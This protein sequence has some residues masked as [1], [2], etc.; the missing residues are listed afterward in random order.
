M[1]HNKGL[2]FGLV[3]AILCLTAQMEAQNNTSYWQQHVDYSMD[4]N[5]DVE[6]YQYSGTQKLV[7]TNNS[8]DVLSRVY[9][10]LFFNAFQPGS[11]MDMRLQSVAD[12]DG[13]MMAD[14]KSRIASLSPEEMGYL[15]VNSLT[16][17]NQAVSF[18]E[19]GTILVVELNKPIPAGGKTTFEMTFNGQIPLQIRRSG[20]NSSEGVALSMSQ[21]Y[22]KL[23]EYDFEGWHADPYI[24][25]EFHGVW[26]D[27]DVKL[28]LDKKY[29][30][31]GTGYL[32]NP[33]E[34]GHGYETPGSKIKKT[35][36]KTLTWHFK[37]P[38]VHDFMWAADPDYL[39]DTL[40]VE[41]GPM[42]HFF[43]KNDKE[44]VEN[45]KKLQPKTAEAMQFFN[46]NI[47]DYPYEQY[48]VIQGG[49][50][51]MEYAMSTLITGG[52]NF[53]SLVGVMVHE[54]AHSWFQHVLA[55]NESKHEWMDEGFTTFISSLCMDQIMDQKK[56][57]P[58]A[59]SYQGYYNLVASGKEQPQTTHA[60]RYE[61]NFAYGVAAYSKGAIFL[62]QL[63][64]IIGQD[65]LMETLRKYYQDFKFKHPTP[66]DIKRTAEKV[67]GMELDWYL[68]DWTQTTNTID[69]GI[70]TVEAEGQKTKVSLERIGLM[71]MPLDILVIYNDGTQETFY[72]PLRMMYGEKENPY[73]HLKRTVLQDWPW[74]NTNYD[75]ILDKEFN[76]VKAIVL[77]PSQLMADV[78]EENNVW[79]AQE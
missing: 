75:L 15:R 9:Y 5:V 29:V 35:K 56:E 53:G 1:R 16:Q 45:W 20:R 77:D 4:V 38:M 68:T 57:N 59:G 17:D 64:Y 78:N 65:K 42:L 48:S 66:N 2:F 58:F 51:G 63:G 23:A 71:P 34:V 22:P 25:R 39:H 74:A 28:T 40:K 33:E 12:P 67:S 3:F 72:A 18:V 8:P 7:Y 69:Y 43:Y 24:A 50:G 44:I 37:A 73:P 49:D 32:Q 70:K 41:N 52:R 54:M 61:L 10:H 79:Q 31:G 30:V 6:K 60:D 36:G 47:G 26:G 11:E 46:K 76:N 14:G 55:S 62:S 27:F 21:W 19:E 13:R